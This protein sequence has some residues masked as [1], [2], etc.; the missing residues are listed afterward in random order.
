MILDPSTGLVATSGNGVSTKAIAN[1]K[2]FV[3]DWIEAELD[4]TQSTNGGS[5]PLTHQWSQNPFSRKTGV[6]TSAN[7][8]TPVVVLSSGPGAY[9]F[10]LTVTDSNGT[11]SNDTATIILQ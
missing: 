4:G 1:P 2:S 5:G 6:I 7:S 10:T 8:P 11:Q 9:S 3:T